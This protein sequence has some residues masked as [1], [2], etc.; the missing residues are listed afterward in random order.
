[1]LTLIDL[2][3][4]LRSVALLLDTVSFSFIDNIYDLF[5]VIASQEI[6]SESIIKQI[7]N[8]MYVIVGLFAFFRIAVFLINSIIT[9]D[10]LFK[11]GTGLSKVFV[12]TVIMLVLLVFAPTIFQL[13]RDFSKTIIKG[14]YVEKI[15]IKVDSDSKESPGKEMQKIAI[16]GVITPYEKFADPATLEIKDECSGNCIKAVECLRDISGINK[17]DYQSDC[18]NKDGGVIWTKI[19]DYNGEK[20]SKEYVYNYKPFVLT[21]VGWV[22]TW[23][24]L[25]FTLDVAKRAIELAVLEILSPLFIATIVDPKSMQSGPF[26]KWLKACGTS[27]ASLFLRIAAISLLILCTKILILWHPSEIAIGSF[28]KLVLLLGFLIFIKQMPKWFANLIGVSGDNMGLGGLGIKKKLADAA[29][30]GGL[31]KSAQTATDNAKKYL[32][33]KGKNFA[34][35]RLRNT[36]ARIGAA[37][38]TI[39]DNRALKKSLKD[40]DAYNQQKKGVFSQARKAAIASQANNYGKDAQGLMKDIGAGYMIGRKNVNAGAKSIKDKFKAHIENKDAKFND[41]SE[42]AARKKRAEDADKARGMYNEVLFSADGERLKVAGANGK[43]IYLNPINDKELN[44]SL[45]YPSSEYA[46]YSQHGKNLITASGGKVKVNA[47]GE[48]VDSSNKVLASSLAEYGAQ[49]MS[50]SGRLAVKSLI[51]SNASKDVGNYQQCLEQKDAAATTYTR[52]ITAYNDAKAKLSVNADYRLAQN[53]VSSYNSCVEKRDN[54]G[55]T[56]LKIKNNADYADLSSR[57]YSSL[58][59]EEQTRLQSYNMKIKNANNDINIANT[60]IASRQSSYNSAIIKIDNIEESYGIKQMQ[61][62][63]ENAKQQLD[64]FEKEAKEYETKFK[65]AENYEIDDNGKLKS[66]KTNPYEVSI[67]GKNYVPGDANSLIKYEEIKSI[68]DNKATKAKEKYEESKQ[69]S[70]DNK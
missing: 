50:Y 26:K 32:G 41:P 14:K 44:E 12:N 54:A 40:K 47:R 55:N 9:P 64:A 56:I 60:E 3:G 53:E 57:A 11:S 37:K 8:N 1:M 33:Q 34:A 25:S 46:A 29:L 68:L 17:K 35:N 38:E 13:S 2:T 22:L 36:T 45:N 30:V 59:P 49:S 70:S 63:Y 51:A 4:S 21:I 65:T 6:I 67:G 39:S 5:S 16:A 52:E 28:G 48:V 31:A 24:L 43:D 18:I 20:V 27:Y 23:I 62:N 69:S 61:A 66:S 15:F 58:T 7:L 10:N 19:S 42:A